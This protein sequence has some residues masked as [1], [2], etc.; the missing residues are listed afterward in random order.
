MKGSHAYPVSDAFFVRRTRAARVASA[1][2]AGPLGPEVGT[3]CVRRPSLA[4][5]NMKGA[6]ISASMARIAGQDMSNARRS[7]RGVETPVVTTKQ[8]APASINA[9]RSADR[10]RICRS[11]VRMTRPSVVTDR[12]HLASDSSGRN[13]SPWSTTSTLTSLSARPTRGP[14]SRSTK[15]VTQQ[16]RPICSQI[17]QLPRSPSDSF[18][19]PRRDPPG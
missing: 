1:R 19:T 8:R 16:S 14:R 7:S 13:R 11:R 2:A 12:I 5:P 15:K 4:M 6:A 17:G 18:R 9:S 10:E 3:Y